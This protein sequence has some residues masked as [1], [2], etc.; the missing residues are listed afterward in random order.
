[1]SSVSQLNAS[2]CAHLRAQHLESPTP[3]CER[4]FGLNTQP[5]A[6]IWASR[7]RG[8]GLIYLPRTYRTDII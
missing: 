3:E 7:L 8:M 5:G 2:V 6:E 4:D 1:M